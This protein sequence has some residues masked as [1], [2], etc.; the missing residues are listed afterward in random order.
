MLTKDYPVCTQEQEDEKLR[1][2][3]KQLREAKRLTFK[4]LADTIEKIGSRHNG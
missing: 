1:A 3:R 4:V 2:A